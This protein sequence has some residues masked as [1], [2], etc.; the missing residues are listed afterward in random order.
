M[1]IQTGGNQA[2]TIEANGD[3]EVDTGGVVNNQMQ[4]RW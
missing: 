1:V 2:F 4:F 3:F